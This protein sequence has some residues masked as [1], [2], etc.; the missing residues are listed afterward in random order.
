MSSGPRNDHLSG[1]RPHGDLCSALLVLTRCERRMDTLR[2]TLTCIAFVLT[3]NIAIADEADF[4]RG[5]T[6]NLLIGSGVGG[7]LD[8]VARAVARHLGKHV[9]GNPTV[10]PRNMVG[11]G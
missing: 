10:V 5:K 1:F 9:P 6:L 7:G 8:Q 3:P 11:A 4:Y 2:I